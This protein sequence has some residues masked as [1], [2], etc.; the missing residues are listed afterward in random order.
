M[1]IVKKPMVYYMVIS[2]VD[3]SRLCIRSNTIA[4]YPLPTI[5]EYAIESPNTT[6]LQNKTT[7]RYSRG[8]IQGPCRPFSLG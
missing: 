1:S 8:I 7:P 4:S 6:W 2:Y 3:S 5:V